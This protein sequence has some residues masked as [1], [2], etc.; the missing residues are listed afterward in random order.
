MSSLPE[1]VLADILSRLP[2]KQL[3]RFR[4]VSSL[5]RALIDSSDFVKLHLNRSIE[6]KSNLSLILRDNH[7][8]YSIEFDSLS[9]AVTA[10]QLDH[11]PLRCQDYGTEV[12][13]SCNGLLCLANALD[14]LVL[15][16]PSNRNSRRLP[17]AAVE[18]QNLSKYYENRIY[19]FGYDSGS[20][21]YKVVRIVAIKGVNDDY[22]DYE[23]KVYSLKSNSWHRAKKFPHFPNLKKSGGAL[24]GG[25]LHWVVTEELEVYTAGL[26]VSFDLCREEYGFV[27]QPD[28]SD[29]NFF[30]SV[31]ELEGCLSVLCYY[32]LAGVHLW[33]MK[34]YGVKESW[35]KLVT[36]AEPGV[37]RPPPYMRPL[38]YSKNGGERLLEQDME[39]LLWYDLKRKRVVKNVVIHGI[40]ELVQVEMCVGSLVPINSG[41]GESESKKREDRDEKKMYANTNLTSSFNSIYFVVFI[42]P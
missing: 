11:H 13:G 38:V 12:W 41:V 31:Q 23:V 7:R 34:D 25:A 26:I 30:M 35:T 16:N 18:F 36:V 15:W 22:F 40:E 3:L 8:L 6:T 27:P 37:V 5:W 14:T 42:L 24:A 29:M 10:V 17:H 20:D 33:V 4:S 21:D 9:S 1:E 39:G 19:G 32:Y 28:Y 2:V